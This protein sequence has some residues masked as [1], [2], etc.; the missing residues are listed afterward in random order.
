MSLK[1]NV[2]TTN[3]EEEKLFTSLRAQV[4][5][6]FHGQEQVKQS[7]H[8]ALT[9]AKKRKEPL[10]HTLLYGPPISRPAYCLACP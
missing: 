3:P 6:E 7:L 9:A 8:V 5:T 10:E 4:W 2:S 1:Q